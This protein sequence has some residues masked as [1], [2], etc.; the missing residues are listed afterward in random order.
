V[1]DVSTAIHALPSRRRYSRKYV[2]LSYSEIRTSF[3][4]FS[5]KD[6]YGIILEPGAFKNIGDYGHVK[7]RL[8]MPFLGIAVLFLGVEAFFSSF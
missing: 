6:P 8:E 2:S 7:K 5:T 4:Y 1:Q 3:G